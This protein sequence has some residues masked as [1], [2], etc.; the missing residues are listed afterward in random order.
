MLSAIGGMDIEE[1]ARTQ[2][3]ALVRRHIDPLIGFQPH[4]AR[5]L[6]YG[7]GIDAEAVGGVVKVLGA[8][9][10]AFVGLDAML[11]EINP[12]VLHR[13]R[14]GGR[15]R[16][17]G[18]HRRQLGLPSPGADGDRRRPAGGP[19]G[20][21]GQGA[22]GH[23]REARRRRRDPGQRRRAR[24]EHARRGGPGGRPPGQLP[25]RRRRLEGR[26]GGHRSGGAA[27]RREGEGAARQHLRRH[28]ALRRGGRGA[29]D[30]PRPAR[31]HAPHRGAPGRHQRGGGAG[32][33][34]RARAGERRG[35]GR[36]CSPPPGEPSAW[37]RR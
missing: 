18:H 13:G 20:A 26:R 22:R 9:Y 5:S 6:A 14:P 7:A 33:H 30:R 10:D 8:L 15:A 29:A 19:A 27:E 2:P 3:E 4:D 24:D 28:H 36:R 12:L 23:L 31:R 16:R 11:M 17:Q 32:D 21:D 35:G 37:P 1:V 34:R 25:G